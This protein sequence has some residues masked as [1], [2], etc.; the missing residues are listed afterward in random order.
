MRC[1]KCKRKLGLV[2]FPCKCTNTYCIKCRL[3]E[4]HNC[5]Y[6]HKKEL[7]EKL[8]KDLPKIIAKKI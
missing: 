3:P 7:L 2:N 4:N 8:K 5:Q 6:D 1:F